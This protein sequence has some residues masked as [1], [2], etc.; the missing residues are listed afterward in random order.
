MVR[1]LPPALA[2]EPPLWSTAT[3]ALL[4]LPFHGSR[5]SSG[6]W[7]G[8]SDTDRQ[9]LRLVSPTTVCPPLWHTHCREEQSPSVWALGPPSPPYPGCWFC[10]WLAP[11]PCPP[12]IMLTIGKGQCR[13]PCKGPCS[14]TYCF[15]P[16]WPGPVL[17]LVFPTV[18]PLTSDPRF[19]V[20]ST[21][22]QAR[23]SL[24]DDRRCPFRH[25]TPS[26]EIAVQS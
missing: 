14:A 6:A 24:A 8:G 1:S 15:R 18:L 3:A 20:K 22:V 25:G 5:L 13:A 11:G 16:R 19:A 23:L 10:G 26:L 12:L 9:G 21:A 17:S 7:G 2:P 4:S